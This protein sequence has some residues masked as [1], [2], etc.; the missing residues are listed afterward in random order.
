MA[1]VR[2][3]HC[4][5]IESHYRPVG[6]HSSAMIR[7][8]HVTSVFSIQ[9]IY[10]HKWSTPCFL[11]DRIVVLFKVTR[12]V[13]IWCYFILV[14]KFVVVMGYVF[15]LFLMCSLP[16]C[17]FH[18]PVS[19]ECTRPSWTTTRRPWRRRR[20]AA[21]PTASS[22]RYLRWV[23]THTYQSCYFGLELLT[24]VFFNYTKRLCLTKLYP[25]IPE[26]NHIHLQCELTQINLVMIS[27]Y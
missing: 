18:R 6:L 11:K 4:L 14:N 8:S 24:W 9:N 27:L 3:F 12:H 19:S 10:K 17:C 5:L 25:F 15:K 26:E 2:Y 20:N 13:V 16:T 23:Q 7:W 22:K 21:T 1:D